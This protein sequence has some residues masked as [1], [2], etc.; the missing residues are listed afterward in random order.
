[1]IPRQAFKTLQRLAKGFPIVAITGPRQ[2]GKTTLA[3]ARF[4]NKPYVNLENPAELEFAT[5]DPAR[6]LNRFPEGAILDEIQRAP[7]L[8]SWLQTI[9]DEQRV[10]GQFVVTGSAQFGLIS[11]VSQSLA[12][13]VGRL[14]LLPLSMAE[15]HSADISITSPES[16]ILRGGYPTL[17]DRDITPT[18]WFANYVATYIERDVRQII[19]IKDLS[20]FQRFVRMCAARSGQLLNLS[21]LAA[22][23]GISS[24]TAKQWLS[25]LEAS[26]LTVRLFPYHQNFG[27][28]LVKSQ[29]LYFLDTGLVAW[30]LGIRDT[31]TLETHASRGALFETLIVSEL[32]KSRFHQGLPTDL[33]FWRDHVGHEIDLV[34]ETSDGPQVIEIKSGSTFSAD[35]ISAIVKW[36][37]FSGQI[38]PPPIVIY[39]GEDSYDR[40]QCRVYTWRDARI[41]SAVVP[42]T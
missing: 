19:N 5:Q 36:Q 15:L 9:V 24:V 32:I 1:M 33:Y 21:S 4:A 10:M 30:L 28:R 42:S 31:Q 22:D 25:V 40:E 7:H 37:K 16:A 38:T 35:W 12:G 39:G 18:D 27:K 34:H 2:S 14:E 6:F 13:R 11:G 29:K 17:F 23:C 3:K 8:F 20:T 41:S 26:Y